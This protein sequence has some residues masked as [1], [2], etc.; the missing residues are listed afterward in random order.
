MQRIEALD[1][2][3]IKFKLRYEKK[4]PLERVDSLEK[5][6]K[7]FLY[8]SVEGHGVPPTRDIDEMWHAHLLD[9]RK[10]A[11]DCQQI[12]GRFLDHFPYFGLLGKGD[13]EDLQAGAEKR[14]RL[15]KEIFGVDLEES[16]W[17]CLNHPPECRSPEKVLMAKAWPCSNP[18][19]CHSPEKQP[20]VNAWPCS[21]PPGCHSPEKQPM[22]NAW[23]C[24]NPPGCH[25][26]E[27]T[28]STWKRP[29]RKDVEGLVTA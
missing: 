12:C 15:C 11:E 22:V 26:P 14:N 24:S 13:A 16:A 23:P 20:M 8:L 21:N 10:Y 19:G 4:W 1:L 25:S 17:P 2:E 28:A 7:M 5:H 9:T 27:M 3:P 6:Y 29:T 18:P